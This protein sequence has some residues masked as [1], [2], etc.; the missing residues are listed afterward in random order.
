MPRARDLMH[1][2]IVGIAVTAKIALAAQLARS[3]KVD[4]L[5]VLDGSRLCGV[6]TASDLGG[7]GSREVGSVMREPVYVQEDDSVDHVS[8]VMLRL[9]AGRIP[10]VDSRDTMVCVGIIT[11]SDLVRALKGR[12]KK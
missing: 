11:S 5:P 12:E 3:A 4:L 1:R 2:D 6:V 8:D 7:E 10:V 9:S